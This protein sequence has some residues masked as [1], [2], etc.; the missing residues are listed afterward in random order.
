MQLISF[1]EPVAIT[2]NRSTGTF[3]CQFQAL[4]P[5]VISNANFKNLY[6]GVKS[7]LHKVTAYDWRMENFNVNAVPKGAKVLYFNGSGGFGDHIM[8]WPVIQIL[9][10]LGFEV[11]VLAELGVEQCYWHFPWVKSIVPSPTPQGQIE[12]W[13]HMAFM[14]GV[15]NF[16]EH[17][18]QLHPVDTQLR[19]FGID[20][21]TI[22]P[23]LKSV[24]PVFAP[25]EL[26]NAEKFVGGVKKI[27]IFQLSS[28]S[29]TRSVAKDKSI[30]MLAELANRFKDVGW[31]AIYDRFV[32]ER[33]VNQAQ[34]LKLPNV[35]VLTF[36]SLRM[37]WAVVGLA[38]ICVGPDSML[39]HI[40]GS[41]GT[42]AIGLWGPMPPQ[43]RIRYYKNHVPIWHQSACQFAPCFV[44]THVFPNYCPPTPDTRTTCSVLGAIEVED[45]SNAAAR[46]L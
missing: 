5:Y 19:K 26:A 32:D 28:T 8:S 34:A 18:D 27:G 4:T 37:L 1:N 3:N 42:P 36:E 35:K 6:E 12:M 21:N 11:H 13:K 43:S 39:I 2:V 20:P 10:K 9:H 38:S 22:D 25:S 16:D 45:V 40:A 24:K 14:E 29:P 23:S 17:P 7:T 44:A 31:V 41:M 30:E 15:V 46:F 33:L